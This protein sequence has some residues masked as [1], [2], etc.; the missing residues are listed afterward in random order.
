MPCAGLQRVPCASLLL[1]GTPRTC[2]SPLPPIALECP[3]S[4]ARAL[5]FRF[6]CRQGLGLVRTGR[7]MHF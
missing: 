4:Q 1:P 6:K 7:L 3:P 5:I 2:P